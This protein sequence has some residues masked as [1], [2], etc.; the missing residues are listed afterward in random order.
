MARNIIKLNLDSDDKSEKARTD[1]E[2]KKAFD[3]ILER[4]NDGLADAEDVAF[5]KARRDYLT[6]EQLVRGTG[7]TYEQIEAEVEESAKT[8]SA[9]VSLASLKKDAL[10]AKATELGIELTGSE[11]KEDLI[12]LIE[13]AQANA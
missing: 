12:A 9:D 1:K 4:A 3:A 10:V 7:L 5:L 8:G 13:E 2:L 6:D 11:K